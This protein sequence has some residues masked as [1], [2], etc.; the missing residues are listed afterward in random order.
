LGG[1]PGF[2]RALA[3]EVPDRIVRAI[4]VD[5]ALGARAVAA[6]VVDELV[7]DGPVDVVLTADGRHTREPVVA[8]VPRPGGDGGPIGPFR[9]PAGSVVLL[10]GGA[11]GITAGVA[12]ALAEA[13]AA[14]LELVGRSPWPEADEPPDLVA[15]ADVRA[16]RAA[17]AARGED[18]TPAEVEARCRR[19]LAGRDIRR[20]VALATAAGASVRYHQADV[21]DRAAVEAV[22]DG[23]YRRHDRLDGVVHGAGVI[24][25]RALADKTAES[26]RRV[27]GTKVDAARALL[28]AVRADVGFVVLFGS[29]SGVFGNRGQVDY[30]AAN[31]AL[32]AI[33]HDADGGRLAGRVLSVD[34]GPWGGAGM[35]SEELAQAYARRGVGLIDPADGL[36]ALGA[37]LAALQATGRF[38]DP[39]VI[40]ARAALAQFAAPVG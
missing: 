33:A 3:H 13:G 15:A 31:D 28:G 4:A 39:Q 38:P 32:D 19:L 36:A 9:L 17:V 35:V 21:S 2:V 10:T 24:E 23:V 40:V 1:E 27:Y 29:V 16:L 5:P 34:W 12:V 6:A 30:A 8:E 22:V 20:T 25:D 26:F 11:R 37:E 7:S 18:R 14:H